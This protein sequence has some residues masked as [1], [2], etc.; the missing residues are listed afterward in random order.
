M[1]RQRITGLATF[2]W[3]IPGLMVEPGLA[4]TIGRYGRGYLAV[5]YGSSWPGYPPAN[6]LNRVRRYPGPPAGAQT[7][8]V[9][10]YRPLIRAIT[11][12]R[13]LRGINCSASSGPEP[14]CSHRQ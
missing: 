11:S 9:N 10:D 5:P 8:T 6:Y 14:A 13:G 12:L 7:V 3:I 2:L 4:Q 1:T